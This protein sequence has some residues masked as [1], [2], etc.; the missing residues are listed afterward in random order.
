VP[1][2]G[3][4]DAALE[5]EPH[6]VEH[7]VVLKRRPRDEG[8]RPCRGRRWEE[9][10]SRGAGRAARTPSMESNE[11]AFIL[12]TSGTTAK[13]KL[14]VHTHGG[15]QV[16]IASMGRWVFGLKRATSG[17]PPP[18]SAG[19]SATATS[20]TPR[21]SPAARPSPTRARIDHPR[22]TRIWKLV[23]EFGVTAIFTSPTAVRLLMRY[24]EDKAQGADLSSLER[25]FC[26]GEVLNAPRLGSGS[27]SASSAIASPSSTTCGRPRPEDPSSATPYGLGMLPIKPGS[28]G[29]PLP[30]IE[31]AVVTPEGEPCGPDEKGIMVIK[32]P[33]PGLIATLWGEP[34]RYGADYWGRLPGQTGLLHRATPP[35]SMPTATSGSPAAPTRSSRSAGHRWHDRGRD[36]APASIPPVAEAGVTGRPTSS[37]GEVISAFVVLKQGQSRSTSCARSCSTPCRRELGPS[38]SSAS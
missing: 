30:G 18:T 8:D 34:E 29:I 21:S 36:R 12:A 2:K 28:A 31:A 16:H 1:L 9:F 37:R 27:R 14:A 11:P 23:E 5:G 17:G 6:D 24:G 15:Y 35:T 25:V 20:S 13:P 22:P 33:F 7:V 26:A 19:S 10:L 32:R 3:I 4:V 38:P